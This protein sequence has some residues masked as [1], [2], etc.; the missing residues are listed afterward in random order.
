[1]GYFRNGYSFCTRGR[2]SRIKTQNSGVTLTTT[3]S[4]FANSK[5]RN[6]V[7]GDVTYYGVIE[8][9]IELDFWSQV[10]VVLFKCQWFLANVDEFGLTFVNFKEKC[11]QNDPFVLE[12][13]VHRASYWRKKDK[14]RKG[15][16]LD[17]ISKKQSH[18]Y[19]IFNSNN[20]IIEKYIE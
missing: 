19:I 5:D 7:D 12:S 1:M 9:I 11:S 3:T 6:P 8:E 17:V 10:S 15:F 18:R 14:K 2:D 13:Q 20:T 16:S 4:S